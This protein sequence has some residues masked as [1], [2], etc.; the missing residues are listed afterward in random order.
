VIVL[1]HQ[2]QTERAEVIFIRE[3]QFEDRKA[4]LVLLALDHSN[5]LVPFLICHRF[6]LDRVRNMG[7]LLEDKSFSSFIV[8]EL[9]R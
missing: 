6:S 9:V 5:N 1:F 4:V 3:D 8:L 2:K 7:P